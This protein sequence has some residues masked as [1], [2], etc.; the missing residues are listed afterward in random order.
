[1]GL[2]WMPE[3]QTVCAGPGTL[4]FH[5][6]SENARRRRSLAC[7]FL[8]MKWCKLMNST[9][10]TCWLR[11]G[12][13]LRLKMEC[14]KGL[15]SVAKITLNNVWGKLRKAPNKTQIQDFTEHQKLTEF[16]GDTG[17]IDVCSIDVVTDD[18]V[19]VYY[20]KTSKDDL[21]AI[22]VNI[23]LTCFTA[24]WARLHLYEV[25]E[26]LQELCLYFDTDSK[27]ITSEPGQP[28]PPRDSWSRDSPLRARSSALRDQSLGSRLKP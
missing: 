15:R 7:V 12:K 13:T 24:Y 2:W 19:E 4:L 9:R 14:N 23:F 8:I 27:V 28:N 5:S 16:L 1:M 20:K 25:V 6:R 18:T 3:L 21:S 26:L 22:H 10:L 17:E 11:K